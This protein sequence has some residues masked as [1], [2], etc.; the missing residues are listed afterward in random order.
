RPLG[1]QRHP[2]VPPR[3]R[4]GVERDSE[5]G[6]ELKWAEEHRAAAEPDAD[7]DDQVTELM[8]GSYREADQ[9]AD[10]G[11]EDDPGWGPRAG[12]QLLELA[13]KRMD[14]RQPAEDQQCQEDK[15][16]ADAENEREAGAGSRLRERGLAVEDRR[17]AREGIGCRWHG[18]P[19]GKPR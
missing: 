4:V 5:G 18:G 2:A 6:V 3:A 14:E 7:A 15:A 8:D 10:E 11:N 13:M 19:P 17:S 12:E 1:N 9:D 16:Q